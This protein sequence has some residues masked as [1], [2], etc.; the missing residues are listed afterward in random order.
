ML[1]SRE[2]PTAVVAANDLMALGAMAEFRAAGLQ[3]PRDVS[4]VG[5]DDIAFAALAEPP[6][7]T[8]RLPLAELG[9]RAVEALVETINHPEQLGT[10]IHI[11]THLV[12][13]GSTG[14]SRSS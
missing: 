11:P 10:E 3:L 9:R 6:L 8:V 7:T 4:V 1:S 2:L 13:R 12:T 14:R 5:F